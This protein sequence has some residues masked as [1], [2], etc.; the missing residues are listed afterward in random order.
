MR[1]SKDVRTRCASCRAEYQE[2]G[3]EMIKVWVKNKRRA[4]SAA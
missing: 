2:A 4:A 3:F 1:M